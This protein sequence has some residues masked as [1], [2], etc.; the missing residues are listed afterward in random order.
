MAN[1]DVAGIGGI[2]LMFWMLLLGVVLS[3]AAGFSQIFEY[4]VGIVGAVLALLGTYL[5]DQERWTKLALDVVLFAL[6]IGVYSLGR[7]MSPRL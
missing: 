5:L 4:A 6:A 7:R 1:S 3:F 2:D